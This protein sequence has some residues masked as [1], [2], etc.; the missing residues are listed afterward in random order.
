MK[1][2]YLVTAVTFFTFL[3]CS[4]SSS[5]MHDGDGWQNLCGALQLSGLADDQFVGDF[6]R[7]NDGA[8]G[9][10]QLRHSVGR[11]ELGRLA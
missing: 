8:Y 6:R 7:G 9:H 10:A 5:G 4:N 11:A 1:F 2:K 3:I